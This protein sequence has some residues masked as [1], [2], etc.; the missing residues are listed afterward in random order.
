[1]IPVRSPAA[2]TG[3]IDSSC[4]G[5]L[6]RTEIVPSRGS[7]EVGYRELVFAEVDDGAQDGVAELGDAPAAGAGIFATKLRR[8]RRLTRRETCALLRRSAAAGGP[9]NR[10]R[11]SRLRKP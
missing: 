7:L 9:N 2:S 4:P 5:S 6:Q 10:V 8:W 3:Q 1:V 11:T